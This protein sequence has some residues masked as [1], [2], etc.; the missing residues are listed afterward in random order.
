MTPRAQPRPRL[1]GKGR[2][3][4]PGELTL[5]DLL[6]GHPALAGDAPA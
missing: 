1:G 3:E 5:H 6:R 2:Q 4:L